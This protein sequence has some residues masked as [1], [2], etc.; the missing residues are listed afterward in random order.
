MHK[1]RGNRAWVRQLPVAVKRAAGVAH[2]LYERIAVAALVL[3]IAGCCSIGTAQ[4]PSPTPPRDFELVNGVPV[5]PNRVIVKPKSIGPYWKGRAFGELS[6]EDLEEIFEIRGLRIRAFIPDVRAL[7]LQ[8][9][10]ISAAELIRLFSKYAALFEYIEP[11]YIVTSLRR[12]QEDFWRC[13]LWGLR[14]IDADDAWDCTAGSERVVVAVVD[15]GIDVDHEDL[16]ME[17]QSNVWKAPRRFN[18]NVN[19][20][21]VPCEEGMPGYD[22]IEDTCRSPQSQHGT[23]IAGTIAA[24]ENEIGVVGVTWKSK[25]MSV[26]VLEDGGG[27][28]SDIIKGLEFVRNAKTNYPDAAD[29]RVVNMSWGLESPSRCLLD[30]LKATA[31]KDIL[32]V[33]AAGNGQDNDEKPFYPAN[34]T[35]IDELIAVAASN[36]HDDLASWSSYGRK[37]VHLMA[38][39]DDIWSMDVGDQY[40]ILDGSSMATAHVSG[41][42]ALVAAACP[43]AT[44]LEVKRRLLDGVDPIRSVREKLIT[45]GRLNVANAVKG[46]PCKANVAQ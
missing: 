33:A 37:K 21:S 3:Y 23:H 36:R 6:P 18:V 38:P 26:R 46:C 10:S 32:L 14:K 15:E 39:G 25:V 24:I 29:I 16:E 19:G 34:Y 13:E 28:L 44:A 43:G 11:D 9:T 40:E 22:A 7:V 17:T 30:S 41:A 1:E 20:L 35:E 27:D 31:A 5:V 4:D 42:V 12:P 2:A 8:S 45:G